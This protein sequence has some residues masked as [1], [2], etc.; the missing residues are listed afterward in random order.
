MQE[1]TSHW[2]KKNVFHVR[3]KDYIV[4]K[5]IDNI[6]NEFSINL[7]KSLRKQWRSGTDIQR[8]ESWKQTGE[9]MTEWMLKNLPKESF[10]NDVDQ[11]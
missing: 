2:R 6:K 8:S 4:M 7:L 11:R 1:K 3:V 10:A 5:I 9:F